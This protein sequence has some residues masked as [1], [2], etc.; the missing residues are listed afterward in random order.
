M[1]PFGVAVTPDG[2][3]ASVTNFGPFTS[4]SE[5]I[6]AVR[7]PTPGSPGTVST[8]DVKTRIKDPTDIAVGALPAEL[9]VTPSRR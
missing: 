3:T 5:A 9:A 8:I 1:R 6:D 7:E 2:K 4:L